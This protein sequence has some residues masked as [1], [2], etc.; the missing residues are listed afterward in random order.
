MLLASASA[1]IFSAGTS[2]S[3]Q[4]ALP[5]PS[6][7][8]KPQTF[9]S[10]EP[11]PRGKTF[12]IA[13]VVEIARGFHMNSHKPTDPYLIATTLTPQVSA[14]FDL[15]DTIY[16]DGRDEKFAFSPNKPLNVYTGRVTLRLKLAAHSDAPLGVTTVPLTLRYQAC[17]D[18][19][20]LQ[21][22]KI[23]VDAKFEVAQAGAKSQPTHAEIFAAK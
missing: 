20:C 10:I 3:A 22:V 15:V 18:T 8:V 7:V 13:V 23:P 16:P 19:T 4:E 2:V 5:K 21:P 6:A 17:N 1:R 14:G 9:V 11:V 12:D